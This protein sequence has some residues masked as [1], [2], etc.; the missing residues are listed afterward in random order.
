M[1]FYEKTI[2]NYNLS[3]FYLQEFQINGDGDMI[4]DEEGKV[5]VFENKKEAQDFKDSLNVQISPEKK[6]LIDIVHNGEVIP[7]P[8]EITF[9]EDD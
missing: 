1:N 5:M 7:F 3:K 4:Y 2:E 6:K 8:T 9:G